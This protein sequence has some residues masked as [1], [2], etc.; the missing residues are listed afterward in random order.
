MWSGHTSR[1]R[2]PEQSSTDFYAHAL[3]A[4]AK[5]TDREC[6]SEEE[7][8]LHTIATIS[9]ITRPRTGSVIITSIAK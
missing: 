3:W 7:V 4:C 1:P 2:F 9:N 5:S 8:S 6:A